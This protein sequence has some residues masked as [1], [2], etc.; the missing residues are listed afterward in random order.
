MGSSRKVLCRNWETGRGDQAVAA[1]STMSPVVGRRLL[2]LAHL[3]T[4]A[5]PISAFD[6]LKKGA[7]ARGERE[8]SWVIVTMTSRHRSMWSVAVR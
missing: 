6:G 8:E 5:A 4:A 1:A 3:P 2:C 7:A